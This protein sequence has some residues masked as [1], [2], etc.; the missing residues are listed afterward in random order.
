M[1]NG[2]AV[3]DGD[4]HMMEPHDIWRNYIDPECRERIPNVI[5][6]IGRQKHAYGPSEIHPEGFNQASYAAERFATIGRQKYG[7]AFESYWSIETRLR[8]MSSEGIDMM[9]CFPTSG[10]IATFPG[11]AA[12]LQVALC[13]AYN[14]WAT[15]FCAA[16][17]GRVKFM[18]QV[19]LERP[20]D[21]AREV[22]RLSGLREVA[23]VMLND[24]TFERF[25]AAEEYR[26]LWSALSDAS[27]PAGFHGSVSQQ[28][29]F[30]AW[31]RA[32][33][34]RAAVGHTLSFPMEAMASLGGLILGGV[35]ERFPQ[36]RVGFYEGNAGWVPWFLARLDMHDSGRQNHYSDGALSMSPSEYFSRQCWVAGDSDEATLPTVVESLA[37][38]NIIWNSD[39]PHV[40]AGFPGAVDEFLQQPIADR[41]KRMMLGDN[42][43]ELYGERVANDLNRLVAPSLG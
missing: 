18:A 28:F 43:L 25:W 17:G 33:G 13:R 8:D 12:D 34:Y 36:L 9:V 19:S 26:T 4:G 35:L 1:K 37:G 3:I 6:D 11:V 2:F 7:D 10:T 38:R 39:Y 14:N 40:D 22:R 16:S 5:G 32:G 23:G 20:E 15:D 29:L 24:P 27:L 21:A 30:R 31:T 41:F 42:A